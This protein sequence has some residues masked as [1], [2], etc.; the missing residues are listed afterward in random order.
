MAATLD[1]VR[2]IIY[3][4]VDNHSS[5]RVRDI[6]S[7]FTHPEVTELRIICCSWLDSHECKPD[8]IVVK[9]I[10]GHLLVSPPELS[11]DT[12]RFLI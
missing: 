5:L 6:L 3:Y 9:D 4:L 11:P 8:D 10:T 12:S 1:E 2:D 7:T